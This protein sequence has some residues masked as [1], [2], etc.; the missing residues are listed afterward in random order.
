MLTLDSAPERTTHL[1]SFRLS[2]HARLRTNARR[3]GVA[4]V[5]A[6]LA[7]GRVVY[8]RGAEIHAIGRKEVLRFRQRGI[9]LRRFEGIQ[10]VCR[11]GV[12]VVLTVYR[13]R[14]FRGLRPRRKSFSRQTPL[15]PWVS[16]ENR[17]GVV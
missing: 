15:V 2:C 5:E 14:D 9:D 17:V 8:I 16:D 7:Y 1:R 4:A 3:F 6:A 11:P 12:G 13:N 10:V